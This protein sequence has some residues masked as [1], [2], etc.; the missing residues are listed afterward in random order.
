M[1]QNEEE[2]GGR[3]GL[4]IAG[5]SQSFGLYSKYGRESSE[6]FEQKSEV[7]RFIL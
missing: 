1:E 3:C 6:D 5:P 7:I 2:K 4:R